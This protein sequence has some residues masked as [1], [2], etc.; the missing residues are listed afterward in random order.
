MVRAVRRAFVERHETALRAPP[1]QALA[2]VREVT[3]AEMPV[4][5]ALFRLR[6]LPSARASVYEQLLAAGFR[7][8][9]TGPPRLLLEAHGRPWKLGERVL[10]APAPDAARM[11]LEFVADGER[12]VTETRVEIQDE[13]ARRAFRRYWLVVRPFSGVVRRLWL[14]AAAR[15]A[16]T[17]A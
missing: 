17:T 3:L 13:R 6:G 4:V 12:L 2:A 16:A 8:L 10:D 1:E 7:E 9:E 15:R 11:T 5:R 14:R